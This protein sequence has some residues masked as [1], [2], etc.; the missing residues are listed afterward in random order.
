VVSSISFFGRKIEPV[1]PKSICG[2][3]GREG[4]KSSH[5]LEVAETREVTEPQPR[6]APGSS[7]RVKSSQGDQLRVQEAA[8]LA[9]SLGPCDFAGST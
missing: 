1:G 2:N 6:A 9:N 5:W 4:R 7:A 3:A 8:N